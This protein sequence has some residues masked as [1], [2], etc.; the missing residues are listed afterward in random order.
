MNICTLFVKTLFKKYQNAKH[1]ISLPKYNICDLIK[2]RY[3]LRIGI[4]GYLTPSPHVT[5]LPNL[6]SLVQKLLVYLN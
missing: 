2:M 5:K 3:Y 4:M 6:K 1:L